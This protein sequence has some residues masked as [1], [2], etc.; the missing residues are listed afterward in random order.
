[1]ISSAG[2]LFAMRIAMMKTNG[3]EELAKEIGRQTNAQ[4]DEMPIEIKLDCLDLSIGE[5]RAYLRGFEQGQKK[6]NKPVDE[7]G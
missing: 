1:M 6:L 3:I 2:S 7:I 5:K 4:V